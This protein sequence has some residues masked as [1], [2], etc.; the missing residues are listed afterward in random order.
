MKTFSQDAELP[1]PRCYDGGMC[2]TRLPE[3]QPCC[4]LRNV[5][6]RQQGEVWEG[7][8]CGGAVVGRG[9]DDDASFW[10]V[11]LMAVLCAFP[12]ELGAR[13]PHLPF[14]L[15]QLLP[16]QNAFAAATC[17]MKAAMLSAVVS[18]GVFKSNVTASDDP[19]CVA[20]SD[21]CGCSWGEEGSCA[22]SI[23]GC[24]TE[25]VGTWGAACFGCLEIIG[26]CQDCACYYA[27]KEIGPGEVAGACV[28]PVAQ[29]GT[30]GRWR[31]RGKRNK[32][33][34]F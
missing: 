28:P 34:R 18:G 25:C 15:P 21:T 13:K 12:A 7:F 5:R 31:G 29:Y 23:A 6:R 27:C 26:G 33:G 16:T 4:H 17:S 22:A 9:P 1:D 19:T 24:A 11:L 8:C 10:L 14:P 3:Q 30:Y 2:C 32:G 20:D